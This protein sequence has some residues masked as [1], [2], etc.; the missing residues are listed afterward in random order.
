MGER[1]TDLSPAVGDIPPGCDGSFNFSCPLCR[2]GRVV[3]WLV[4]GG[5]PRNGA[6]VTN[7]LPPAWDRMTIRPSVADEGKCTRTNRGCPGWHGHI[8]NGEV[9]P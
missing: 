7:V 3:V 9:T 5:E 1:L 8:T 2:K 4:L 6:H